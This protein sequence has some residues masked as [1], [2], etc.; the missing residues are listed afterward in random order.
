M[1]ESI[2]QIV[3]ETKNIYNSTLKPTVDRVTGMKDYG[4]TKVTDIKDYGVDKLSTLKDFGMDKVICE[5]I[6]FFINFF[7]IL[8]YLIFLYIIFL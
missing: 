3:A 5:Q 7:K 1:G 2:L 4:V 8:F 6:H